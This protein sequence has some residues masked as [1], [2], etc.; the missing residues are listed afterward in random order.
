[1]P[2]DSISGC[3]VSLKIKD[4]DLHSIIFL[5]GTLDGN[6]WQLL[7]LTDSVSLMKVINRTMLISHKTIFVFLRGLSLNR[8]DMKPSLLADSLSI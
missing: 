1:M 8:N 6:I 4:L 2:F 5:N 3:L 7:R